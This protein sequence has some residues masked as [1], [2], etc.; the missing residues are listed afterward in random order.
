[1]TPRRTGADS[2]LLGERRG[3]GP[4]TRRELGGGVESVEGRNDTISGRKVGGAGRKSGRRHAE[5]T[6]LQHLPSSR[7]DS[8]TGT[9]T[10][11]DPVTSRGPHPSGVSVVSAFRP[12]EATPVGGSANPTQPAINP[13]TL[14]VLPF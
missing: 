8:L 9:G 5:G 14:Y 6:F 1:M 7:P 10:R 3:S 12:S 11:K 4:E 2:G 13:T